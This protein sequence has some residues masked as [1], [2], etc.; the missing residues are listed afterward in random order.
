MKVNRIIVHCTATQPD[1]MADGS[2]SDQV[3]AVRQW[4]LDK[5]WSDIGYHRV[6]SRGGDVAQGRKS[7]KQGAHVKGHNKNTIGI[8]LVGGFGSSVDDQP[9]KNF[10]PEQMK[11][12][13]DE[14]SAIKK[15]HGDH[16]TVHGHNEFAN[17]ACPGFDVGDWLDGKKQVKA[18]VQPTAPR[19]KPTQSKTVKASAT[20]MVASVGS[21]LTT[22]SV[23][24]STTQYIVLG[25][26]G[27][28]LL[29]GLYILR[30][31]LKS[32]AAGWH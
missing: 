22:L 29:A 28:T 2:A 1:W 25:F 5:G 7:T 16:V 13:S 26:T 8:A 19:K 9:L 21:A 20:T 30:E 4:H 15:V 12:L 18:V 17:K 6:I 23:L 27:V 11:T 32:W 3:E 31:R 24:D 14:I 10:T